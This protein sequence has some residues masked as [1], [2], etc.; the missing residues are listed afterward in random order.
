M[1]N[2][3]ICEIDAETED[4]LTKLI[5]D[6]PELS[7]L[8]AILSR[9]NIFH[10]LK[11]ARHEIRHSNML[12]WLMTPSENHSLSDTF[13]RRWLM[14]VV[15]EAEHNL[16]VLSDL[17]S[18][19]EIDALEI[20]FVE[21]ARETN[22]IDLLIVIHPKNRDEW[23]I[24]IEN[25][26]NATQRK[27]QLN[28][29]RS[30]VEKR[31][32]SAEHLLFIFLTKN[33]EE[34]EDRKFISSKYTVIEKVLKS[35]LEE[36]TDIIGPEPKFL[37][38]QY[39]ELLSEDFMDDNRASYLARQIYKSHKKA[40]DFILKNID[41]PRSEAS[42][43][44]EDVLATN[45]EELG[46]VLAPNHKGLVRFLP[47]AWDIPENSGGTAWGTNSRYLLCEVT[48]WTKNAEL[49]ITIG[50]APDSWADK[51]WDRASMP[52]FKQEWKKRPTSFIKPY[53][54]RSSFRVENLLDE[55]EEDIKSK[56]LAWIS[57]ELKRDKFLEAVEEL[58]NM[59][60][61]LDV[62]QR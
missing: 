11:A 60:N 22:N 18:P 47:K 26:V 30:Y 34:P 33:D 5:M 16:E 49:H 29:Y 55:E 21:V 1:V 62:E 50:R 44:M 12:A 41:D 27:N 38:Q 52:P 37:I 35:C 19:I 56:F 3:S 24:C 46:I 31:Y 6:C 13:I 45:Q 4:A 48:F 15:Y 40:I 39:L 43:I 2:E 36:K 20:E 8:E 51:V 61:E 25:K 42:R 14:Q 53:K 59:L 32:T 58:K 57:K 54:S 9:F 7:E 17:P 10:V 28:D 23:V